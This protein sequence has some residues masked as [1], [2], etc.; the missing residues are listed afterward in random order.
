MKSDEEA[1]KGEQGVCVYPC[2]QQKPDT[3][4]H[5]IKTIADEKTPCILHISFITPIH[6]I[7]S[8]SLPYPYHS[9]LPHTSQNATHYTLTNPHSSD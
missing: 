8:L 3:N 2:I 1:R 6:Y 9:T 7:L 4:Y 5:L